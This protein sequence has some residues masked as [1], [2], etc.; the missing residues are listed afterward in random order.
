[1]IERIRRITGYL[2]GDMSKWNSAKDKKKGQSEASMKV[3]NIIHDSI[4]DGE[5]LRTVVF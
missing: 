2:V 3:M 1:M 5:G 4:V